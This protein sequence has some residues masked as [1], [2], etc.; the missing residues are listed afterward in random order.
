MVTMN[1]HGAACIA[2]VFEHPTR[3]AP[4]ASVAQLDAESA[5]GALLDAG[6]T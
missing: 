1:L 4:H 3:H 2:G 5:K 6:L